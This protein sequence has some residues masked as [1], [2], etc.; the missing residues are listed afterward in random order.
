VIKK[1]GVAFV[2]GMLIY[3]AF[4]ETG[5]AQTPFYTGKTITVVVATDAGGSGDLRT[6]AVISVLKKYIPGTPTFT[7][8]YMPGGGGRK[9]ANFVYR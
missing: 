8:Q 6:K 2:I 7:F 4:A 9:A 3:V 5:L 1:S